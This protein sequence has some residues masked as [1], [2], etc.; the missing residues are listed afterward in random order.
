MSV[1]DSLGEE[2]DDGVQRDEDPVQHG[3]P[4]QL[5]L[6]TGRRREAGQRWGIGRQYVQEIR[7]N[8]FIK[9]R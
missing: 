6:H 5:T 2:A 4:R 9:E 1:P 7:K 3:A 8:K